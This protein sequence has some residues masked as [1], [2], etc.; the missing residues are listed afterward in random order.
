MHGFGSKKTLLEDFAS[1]TLTSYT[2][3]VINGYLASVN[4]KQV[5]FSGPS[6]IICIFFNQNIGAITLGNDTMYID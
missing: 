1:G 3:V 5:C 2:V 4:L 6:K